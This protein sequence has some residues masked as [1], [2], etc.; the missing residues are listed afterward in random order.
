MA[1]NHRFGEG[2][3]FR[4]TL[5]PASFSLTGTTTPDRLRLV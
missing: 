2:L 5:V 4:S 1:A 3:F